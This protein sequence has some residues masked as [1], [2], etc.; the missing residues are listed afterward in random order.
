MKKLATV[1]AAAGLVAVSGSASAWW[2][3]GQGEGYA[4]YGPHG[5]VPPPVPHVPP[6]VP[7]A[8]A[9][10]T[11]TQS[12]AFPQ[13]FTRPQAFVP[14][15]PPIDELFEQREKEF[16][17]VQAAF[18]EQRESMRQTMEERRKAMEQSMEEH[19]QAVQQSLEEQRKARQEYHEQLRQNRSVAWHHPYG[20]RR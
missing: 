7:G 16:D 9:E 14:P 15:Q 2:V 12:F 11:E 4:P 17:A 3:P 13:P 1:I 20:V 10:Q 8:T 19:L 5:Y 18:E 6:V